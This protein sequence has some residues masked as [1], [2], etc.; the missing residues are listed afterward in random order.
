MDRVYID[1]GQEAEDNPLR[2]F[3]GAG[4]DY[5]LELIHRC[6]MLAPP[7]WLLLLLT[8]PGH[9]N[10]KGLLAIQ[11][12]N[13]GLWAG[14]CAQACMRQSCCCCGAA[15]AGAAALLFDAAAASLAVGCKLFR[16]PAGCAARP[17]CIRVHMGC[18]VEQ[19][20]SGMPAS[21]GECMCCCCRN[22]LRDLGVWNPHTQMPDRSLYRH[23]VALSSGAIAR[24]VT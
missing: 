15:Q 3:P 11:R 1:V 6:V 13:V 4:A 20:L 9:G 2:V 24:P 14:A 10:A 21:L 18:H 19:P 17:Y 23:F 7:S 12:T 22:G 8:P 16:R 5:T